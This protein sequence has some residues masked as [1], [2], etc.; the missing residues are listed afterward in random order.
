M[1]LQIEH[2]TSFAYDVPISEAYT[3]L[4]L[5]PLETSGQ[6]CISFRI[7]TDPPGVRARPY[8][9]HRG[10]VIQHFDVLEPHDRLT[11]TA[12]SDVLT[13]PTYLD[14]ERRPTQLEAYD[15]LAPTAYVTIS[16]PVAAFAASADPGGAT[17][18]RAATISAVI[19]REFAYET[20]VTD[21]HT[22]A[23]E[24]LTLGRGV[25]QDFA[26]L[27]LATCRSRGILSRYVS[28]YL[29]DP[30]LV[31]DTAASHAWV[32]VY[33]EQRGWVSLDPTHNREQTDAYVR[34]AI[35]RDYAEVP[36]TRGVYKGTA[37]ESLEVRVAIDT[38]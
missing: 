34:V 32:D 2:R 23:D 27:L 3:E 1:R 9:D 30:S 17:A 26:H 15:Y 7:A 19:F 29:Y 37:A 33:D 4:R 25:C 24:V 6:H 8:V 31:G 21:V 18:D 12:T 36:P 10:N 20:G 38:T 28:G 13:P 14:E 11:V 35:G 5:R 22:R 16:A